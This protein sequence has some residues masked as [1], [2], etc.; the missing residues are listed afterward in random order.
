[1][2]S[3]QKPTA[4]SSL[5]PSAKQSEKPSKVPSES[6]IIAKS[7]LPTA[8][9]SVPPSKPIFGPDTKCNYLG[10]S[11]KTI[12]SEQKEAAI[13]LGYDECSWENPPFQNQDY[14]EY[15]PW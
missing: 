12:T 3:S 4:A 6:P 14:I 13:Q 15:Y 11:W 1:M 8:N 5:I 10:T 2:I 9:P 7:V